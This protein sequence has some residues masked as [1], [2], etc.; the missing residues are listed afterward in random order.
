MIWLRVRDRLAVDRWSGADVTV[1]LWLCVGD[2]LVI[3]E[4]MN[5]WM[6]EWHI[7]ICTHMFSFLC[8][9]APFVRANARAH[10]F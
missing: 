1:M 9:P 3:H 5:K 8:K 4:F 7:M 2:V 6:D 10:L